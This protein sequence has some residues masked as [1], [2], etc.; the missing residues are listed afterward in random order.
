[1]K[2]KK[3]DIVGV[4][5]D[6][7]NVEPEK[8]KRPVG[9]PRETCPPKDELIQYGKDMIE[10]VKKNKPLHLSEWYT[11][12]MFFTYDE[13]KAMIKKDEFRPYYEHALKLV[14]L[15][16]LDKESRIR[17]SISQRWQRV[18]FKDLREEEDETVKFKAEC[19]KMLHDTAEE[20][21]KVTV[22]QINKILDHLGLEKITTE[23][24]R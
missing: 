12:E 8:V 23:P 3:D 13:W 22:D 19:Q 18:Y 11:I 10:W 15:Q 17:D 4:Y 16:Y 7:S 2:R 6:E 24:Q 14:G 9:R 20:K 1:M 21:D 5:I